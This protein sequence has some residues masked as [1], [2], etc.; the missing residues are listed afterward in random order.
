MM[1]VHKG[2]H[3]NLSRSLER[4]SKGIQRAVA[5]A[6]REVAEQVAREARAAIVEDS[7]GSMTQTDRERLAASIRVD[8]DGPI[9]RVG[10]DLGLGAELEFGTQSAPARPWLQPALE[11]VAPRVRRRIER[12][13]RDAIR[14]AAKGA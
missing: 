3:R 12:S 13:V 7:G 2:G 4:L 10:T 11:R 1:G 6:V 14:A 9:F 8:E 5:V